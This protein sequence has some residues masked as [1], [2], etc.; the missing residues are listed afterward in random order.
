MY[1]KTDSERH[2]V[3]SGYP[4]QSL[5][6]VPE[7]PLSSLGLKQGEQI[8]VGQKAGTAVRGT[9]SPTRAIPAISSAPAPAAVPRAVPSVSQTAPR[10]PVNSSGPDS[11]A[12]EGGF[13]IHR[14]S[15]FVSTAS[16]Y[17]S[18]IYHIPIQVVPDDNSCL[19]SSVA[20]VFE[21][22]IS[23]AP[24]IRK[25]KYPNNLSAAGFY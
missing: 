24:L 16:G 21:Q 13:L 3:K 4:P 1:S 18:K 9:S 19:F 10:A 5:T 2:P 12:T 23:K 25:S 11:V 14:V 8:I 17:D 15:I 20:L 22:D 6:I 7:L